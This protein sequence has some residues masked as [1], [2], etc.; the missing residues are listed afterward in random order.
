LC[1]QAAVV[2]DSSVDPVLVLGRR[3][4]G[5][6]LDN[7]TNQACRHALEAA[8]HIAASG[9]HDSLPGASYKFCMKTMQ[10]LYPAV[11]AQ[12]LLGFKRVKPDSG[13]MDHEIL[14]KMQKTQHQRLQLVVKK[15]FVLDDTVSPPIT[16]P[17]AGKSVTKDSMKKLIEYRE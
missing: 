17:P 15:E 3:K 2:E 5:P 9:S 14:K 7:T 16:L 10:M 11:C 1:M 12:A 8:E 13:L 4:R 6:A